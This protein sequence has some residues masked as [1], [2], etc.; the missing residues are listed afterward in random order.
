[1]RLTILVLAGAVAGGLTGFLFGWPG[2]AGYAI[3]A[4]MTLAAGELR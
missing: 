3:G 4:G 1:M 2:L